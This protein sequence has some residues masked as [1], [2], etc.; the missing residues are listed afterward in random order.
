MRVFVTRPASDARAWVDGLR[1]RGFDALALPLISIA[2][3][4]A[5]RKRELVGAWRQLEQFRAA[6]FVSGNAVRHF[7]AVRPTGTEW[8]GTTRAWA[9]GAGTRQALLDVGVVSSAIDAPP[10]DAPQ[11]DSETLWTQV[12]EQVKAGDQVLLVRG[13]D[14]G[15]EGDTGRDWLAE[16]LVSAGARVQAVTAY[17]RCVPILDALS[18]T[19]AIAGAEGGAWLF[20]SSQS[21]ANLQALFPAQDWSRARAVC[22]HSRI[23]S[24][25]RAAS[26][27]VVCESR[28]SMEA[29]V[30]A[31]ES[32]R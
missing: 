20:S 12:A 5:P 21:I 10:I 7:F 19:E 17:L 18:G 23:A 11:F 13:A 30:T 2:P 14:A 31:L 26:F 28:P 9:T 1:A 25:A 6:M 16:Q 8:A 15:R 29:V 27:G 4:P 24:T 3:A 22:T 32:F